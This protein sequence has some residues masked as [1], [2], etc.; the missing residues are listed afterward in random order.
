MRPPARCDERRLRFSLGADQ[1][2]ES[3][4]RRGTSRMGHP[5]SPVLRAVDGGQQELNAPRYR[6]VVMPVPRCRFAVTSPMVDPVN[7]RLPRD[8]LITAST[9]F[10]RES[11]G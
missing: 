7:P 10:F 5:G 3:A 9:P 11:E 4:R 2:T 1:A 8:R 6:M